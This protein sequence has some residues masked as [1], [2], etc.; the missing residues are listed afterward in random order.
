MYVGGGL[1]TKTKMDNGAAAAVVVGG[2]GRVSHLVIPEPTDRLP[3][4]PL[5]LRLALSSLLVLHKP[6]DPSSKASYPGNILPR[7]S[8]VRSLWIED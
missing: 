1:D 7:S 8:I 6:T 3:I 4:L 2:G 5:S